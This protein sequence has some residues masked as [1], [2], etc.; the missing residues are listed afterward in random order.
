MRDQGVSVSAK[1]IIS[2]DAAGVTT[3]SKEYVLE[4]NGSDAKA[5]YKVITTDAEAGK[6]EIQDLDGNKV[7]E[8]T[9]G[10]IKAG[11][12]AVMTAKTVTAALSANEV[13]EFYDKDGN[14]ISENNLTKYC[15]VDST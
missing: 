7:A 1:T 12:S 8:A 3:A 6:F 9:V 14:A 2:T 15:A 4:L 10:V 5:N 13:Y 11:E